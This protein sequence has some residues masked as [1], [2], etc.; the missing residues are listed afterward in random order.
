MG[1]KARWGPMGFLVS[2]SKIVPFDNFSTS[3][4]LKTDN[5]ND[6]SGTDTTNQR[7]RELQPMSFATKYMRALGVDPRER[8]AAWEK[9]VG[10]SHPLYIG[11]KRFGPAKMML[12]GIK[13]SELITNN[14]GDF[15]SITL[16]IT[17]QEESTTK[18]TSTTGGAST[19][20][21]SSSGSYLKQAAAD[22]KKAAEKNEA[23]NTT[24]SAADKAEK[25]PRAYKA[26]LN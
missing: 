10:K 24:A 14:D 12:T 1:Y 20:A 11:E 5:G 4:T 22:Y 19:S 15:I 3:I 7:G 25:K 21:A 13:V 16:D 26:V 2:P 9:Q 6:T 8:L 18:K 17:M 23:L